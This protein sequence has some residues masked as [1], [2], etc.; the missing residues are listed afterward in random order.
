MEHDFLWRT[1][2]NLPSRGR[3]GIF[4]RSYY[5]E[6]LIARVHPE[7]LANEGLPDRPQDEKKIWKHRYRSINDLERHLTTNGTQIIKFFLHLSKDE[8]K[9]RF[10]ARIDAAD[11]NW[12]FSEADIT[13]RGFWDEYM[14]AYGK[15]LT[16]TSTAHAPW[17]IVP[18]DDKMNARLIV[19]HVL[20]ERL[21]GLKMAYPQVSAERREQLQAIRKRLEAE[22]SSAVV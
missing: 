13:E 10:L 1:T 18:A 16:A 2:R 9:K 22:P 5:E 21:E 14:Q 4:N 12:K 15:C 7:I 8:Q 11:K 20:L 17:H 19:S 6:V 3:I